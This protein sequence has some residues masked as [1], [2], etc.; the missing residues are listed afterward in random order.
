MGVSV[1]RRDA[2]PCALLQKKASQRQQRR[3]VAP[4]SQRR[5]VAAPTASQRRSR[6]AASQRRSANSVAASLPRR[7]VAA[8]QR[9]NSVAASLPRRSVA[10]SQRQ[11]RRSVAPRDAAS[12]RQQRRSVA[13][14]SSANS[15]AAS[16]QR[17]SVAAPTASQRHWPNGSVAAS[18]R[19]PPP[20]ASQRRSVA[21][22]PAP[23]SVTAQRRKP[24]LR[25]PLWALGI[26]LIIHAS[27]S[28]EIF[29]KNFKA[30]H[31]RVTSH[32][33][34]LWID[35]GAGVVDYD[36]RGEVGVVLFNHGPEDFL[37]AVGDDVA[38]LILESLGWQ[39]HCSSDVL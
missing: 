11:Q 33:L 8:S 28:A 14:R 36:Y 30:L 31:L 37:V 13:R 12:Q 38:Q 2:T 6:V 3:S 23:G 17:R 18:Q 19:H 20:G 27:A 7:S 1:S 35:T 5:S 39:H 4:A 34:S 26:Y 9:R 21:A 15:V 16:L 10:A 29:P 32:K 25:P 22:P 24:T